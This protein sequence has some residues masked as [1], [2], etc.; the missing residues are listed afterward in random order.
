MLRLDGW[1]R[2]RVSGVVG[3]TVLGQLHHLDPRSVWSREATD[4]TPW[5]AEH[6]EQLGAVLGMDLELIGREAAVGEF[7]ADLVARD[8]NRD[9]VVIIENQLNPTDHTHLGQLITYAAGLDAGAIVWVSPQLREEHRQAL[10]WL[11]RQTESD[12][13]GVALELVRIDSSLPAIN[14]RL[15]AFANNWSRR[16]KHTPENR[17][18]RGTGY[19]EFFQALI[20]EL[21]EKHRFTSQRAAQPQNWVH[22]A[23]GGRWN[24]L[25]RDFLD[26]RASGRA[27]HRC[28][29]RRPEFR[30]FRDPGA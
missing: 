13:F 17:S 3:T 9:R 11:N 30:D 25:W 20:D 1:C 29:Q 4:F 7:A 18:D 22:F 15:A 24:P 27:V 26:L 21:R 12:F 2:T 6:L 23:A 5:L 16:I 10:D 14:F 19:Q 28:Q 8:L